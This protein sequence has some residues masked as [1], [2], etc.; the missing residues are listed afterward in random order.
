[1]IIMKTSGTTP[2]DSLLLIRGGY[3][4]NSYVSSTET[5][6]RSSDCS[7]PSLPLS[8]NALTTFV[9]AEPTTLVAA[10]GGWI[11]STDSATG[12]TDS[13]LVLDPIKRR[14]DESRMGSL[15]TKRQFGAA[16]TL[17]QVGVFILGGNQANNPRTSEFLPAGQMQK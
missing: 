13:C 10:C 8:R 6:P 14:W 16:A 3:N 4:G 5:Y 15:T 9:T 11:N 7:S 12:T 1:M 2:Q 17:D